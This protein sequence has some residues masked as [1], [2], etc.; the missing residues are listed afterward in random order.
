MNMEVFK[1]NEFGQVRV[2]VDETTKEPWFVAKD[3][4]E[5]LGL[6][7]PSK[8]VLDI[9]T[10]LETVGIKGVTNSY[11]LETNGGSQEVIIVNEQGLYELIFNSRKPE[12]IKF[13]AWVTS[14]VLPSI[15]KYG[16][17][18]QDKD[19]FEKAIKTFL[20]KNAFGELNKDG[21]PKTEP[22]SGYWRSTKNKELKKELRRKDGV[23]LEGKEP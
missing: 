15:R 12:A 14:E 7:N 20:P 22:V 1:N 17:Y 6:S 9:K 4:C 8:A 10:K 2:V 11:T 23:P 21:I 18:I 19:G 3:V 13:R 16:M 5:I